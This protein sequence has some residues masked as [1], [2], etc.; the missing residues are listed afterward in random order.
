M[1]Y[2]KKMSRGKSRRNFKRGALN[3]KKI[4]YSSGPMRGGLRL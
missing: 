3:V 1:A 4:N 2:G